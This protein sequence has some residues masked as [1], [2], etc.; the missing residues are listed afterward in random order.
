MR[1]III[2]TLILQLSGDSDGFT[3]TANNK[4]PITVKDGGIMEL[5]CTAGKNVDLCEFTTPQGV[6][7][8]FYPTANYPR[9]KKLKNSKQQC[10]VQ[11][12]NVTM[13]VFYSV[14]LECFKLSKSYF[15]FMTLMIQ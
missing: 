15:D 4:K 1:A 11:V 12:S 3:L 13:Q 9:M 5:V 8:S 10:G 2:L 7:R 14:A 6:V